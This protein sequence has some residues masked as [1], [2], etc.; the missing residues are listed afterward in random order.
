[1]PV[2]KETG[3]PRD[4]IPEGTHQA[5]CYGVIDLGT[6]PP[7]PGSLYG[8][9]Q[10]KVMIQWE[11][12]EERIE[13][14]R[15]GEKLSLPRVCSKEFT[16]SLHEKAGLTKFLIA[17]RGKQF[18]DEEKAGFEVGSVLG[19]NCMLNIV[20]NAKGYADIAAVMKLP[21]GMEAKK[22][23]NPIVKYDITDATI[24]ASVPEWIR[25]KIGNSVEHQAQHGNHSD[26]FRGAPTPSDDEDLPF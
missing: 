23:E 12:P 26:S 1:M 21:K 7:L 14:E 2:A 20:H 5:V 13:T 6:Q 9:T 19:A 17:W 24:P 3:A 10:R 15:D 8:K 4:P 11:I 18:T 16:L 22:P 25:K